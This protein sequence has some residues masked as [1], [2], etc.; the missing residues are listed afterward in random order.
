MT[1]G[2]YA[3][4]SHSDTLESPEPNC[5]HDECTDKACRSPTRF[6]ETNAMSNA[7]LRESVFASTSDNGRPR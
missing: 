1:L 3:G 5:I 6:A 7:V 2:I 4:F